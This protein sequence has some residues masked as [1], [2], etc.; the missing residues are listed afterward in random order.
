MSCG[1]F[2]SGRLDRIEAGFSLISAQQKKLEYGTRIQYFRQVP[3]SLFPTQAK[4]AW[5]GHLSAEI[6]RSKGIS[7]SKPDS[8]T[9]THVVVRF[10]SNHAVC[11]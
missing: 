2:W 5:V 9:S 11:V 8:T 7:G 6:D 10:N 1:K 3:A 4:T